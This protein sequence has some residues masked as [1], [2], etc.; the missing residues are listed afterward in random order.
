MEHG[1]SLDRA[2]PGGYFRDQ[3]MPRIFDNIEQRLRPALAE[4]MRV[5]HRADFCVGYFNLRGWRSIDAHVDGWAGGPGHCCRILVGMQRL[6]H[7]ELRS[8]TALSPD[9]QELHNQTA[10]RLKKGLAEEFCEQLTFGA[11]TNQD[12]AGLR[13]LA[14]RWRGPHSPWRKSPLHSSGDASRLTALF[15][16]YICPI[17]ALLTPCQAGAS[18]LSVQR[19]VSPRAAQGTWLGPHGRRLRRTGGRRSGGGSICARRK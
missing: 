10:L 6:P 18:P 7:E 3:R 2:L 5:A 14:R 13:K 1:F 12:E 4:T 15:V 9:R 17:C 16:G 19:G 11:P 8:A